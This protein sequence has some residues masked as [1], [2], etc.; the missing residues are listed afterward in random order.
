MS[1]ARISK[2]GFGMA[3]FPKSRAKTFPGLISVSGILARASLSNGGIDFFGSK[4]E[5]ISPTS[6]RSI[7]LLLFR[8]RGGDVATGTTGRLGFSTRRRFDGAT[9]VKAPTTP[10]SRERTSRRQGKT[11]VTVG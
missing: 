11:A 3:F 4:S 2:Y 10:I 9:F 1:V 5:D 6:T 8:G 7:A